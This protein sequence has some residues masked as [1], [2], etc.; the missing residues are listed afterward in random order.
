MD[1][2]KTIVFLILF[3]TSSLMRAQEYADTRDSVKIHFKQSKIDLLVDFED[4]WKSLNRI[5]NS[6]TG[7]YADSVY[8]LLKVEVIGGA[9]PEGSVM[10]NKWLSERRAQVL[11]NY[12]SGYT[13]L[14]DS[15]R[16][17]K[18]LGRDWNGLIRLVEADVKMPYKEETLGLLNDI[19]MR[20]DQGDL[21]FDDPLPL[22]KTFKEGLPYDYMYRVMFPE[23]R[24]SRVNLWY[25]RML[26]PVWVSP[27]ALDV[28]AGV[29]A[30]RLAMFPGFAAEF[31][32]H[33]E[34]NECGSF[35]MWI[36]TNMLNDVLA[37][38]NLGAEFYLGKSWSVGGNWMYAWWKT[39][40]RH[41]YWRIYGGDIHLRRWFGR[42]AA[43]KPLTGHHAGVYAQTV[44]YDF[45]WGGRGYMGGEPGGN[46]WDRAHWGAGVE[47]GYTLP[48]ARRWD[49]DFTLGVGYLGG[50]YYE[51]IPVDNCYV[52]QAT[53]NR[54]W[55]GPTK[56]E[57]SLV[58]LIGCD[59]YNRRKG[60]EK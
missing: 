9:S 56:A 42:A 25:R 45:E 3:I 58:W 38:P 12:L 46:L 57:V 24:A 49:I 2:F 35:Y 53:K 55:F 52:W 10:F 13:D 47:Y 31:P 21:S 14:P 8:S 41:R 36:S 29:E 40:R 48:I 28:K 4:N 6:L 19:A 1:V 11:F 37:V 44:T 18:Y 17:S 26:N 43:E 20:N 16:I 27:L 30:P 23:L 7:T 15:I 32:V 51:Y 5:T 60:G 54:H 39:D 33:E 50:R 59:N 34:T 22:L